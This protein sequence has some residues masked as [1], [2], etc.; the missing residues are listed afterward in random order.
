MSNISPEQPELLGQSI[1]NEL[2]TLHYGLVTGKTYVDWVKR[3]LA[4]H[5]WCKPSTVIRP[6]TS[7]GFK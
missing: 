5:K 3:F 7:R 2:R 1:R 4:F 6:K